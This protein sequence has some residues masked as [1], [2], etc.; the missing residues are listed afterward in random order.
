M[1]RN[2]EGITEIFRE[3]L[4]SAGTARFFPL[5]GQDRHTLSDDLIARSGY[6]CLVEMKFSGAQ[7][8]D[9]GKKLDRVRR[10]CAA[11]A[12]DSAFRALHDS[13]HFIAARSG[14]KLSVMPYRSRV[15]VPG[16]LGAPCEM[17]A[18]GVNYTGEAFAAGFF[19]TPPSTCSPTED[20]KS[21]LDRL[22]Q[23]VTEGE[24]RNLELIV[25]GRANG[26]EFAIAEVTD[27][28]ELQRLL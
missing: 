8:R 12:S 1:G 21:Y 4:R 19:G 5:G 27:L 6:F 20:F 10:L 2:E 28:H 24:V 7:I 22:L 14:P 13:C 15:C 25:R 26:G 23:V 11:L 9:E 18:N 16:I 17:S 3:T